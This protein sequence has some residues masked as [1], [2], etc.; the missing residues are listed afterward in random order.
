MNQAAAR[1]LMYLIAKAQKKLEEEKH[2]KLKQ[3]ETI[4]KDIRLAEQLIDVMS[5]DKDQD[6]RKLIK[7]NSRLNTIRHLLHKREEMILKD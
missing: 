1:K 4:K 3:V 7:I 2:L 5:E 6:V